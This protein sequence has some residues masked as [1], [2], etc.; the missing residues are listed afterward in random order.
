VG[1][2]DPFVPGFYYEVVVETSSQDVLPSVHVW[3]DHVNTVIPWTLIPPG[4][5]VR[6][7]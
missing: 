4:N 1:P 6:L 5:W 3:Q 7:Q 2:S